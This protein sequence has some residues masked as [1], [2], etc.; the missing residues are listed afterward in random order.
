[1]AANV[2]IYDTTLRDG[3]QQEGIS[4]SVDDKLAIA[5]RLDSLGVHYIEGGFAGANP[6]DDEFFQRAQGLDLKNSVLAGAQGAPRARLRTMEL[7]SL[8]SVPRHRLSPSWARP[9]HGR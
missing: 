7:S 9:L 4:L 1:M 8:C 2:E 5:A 6:K 3:T